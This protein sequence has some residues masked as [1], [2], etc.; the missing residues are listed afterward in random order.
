MPVLFFINNNVLL[1]FLLFLFF[2][3]LLY[4]WV[5]HTQRPIIISFKVCVAV[6][7]FFFFDVF[8]ER[9]LTLTVV[10]FVKDVFRNSFVKI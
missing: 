5:L 10:L 2:F 6:I 7:S 4:G 1:R 8:N 9:D 3:D